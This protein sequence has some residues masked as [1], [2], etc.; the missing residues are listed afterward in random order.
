MKTKIEKYEA[1]DDSI[2]SQPSCTCQ[3]SHWGSVVSECFSCQKRLQLQNERDNISIDVAERRLPDDDTEAGIVVFYQQMPDDI[4]IWC[5]TIWYCQLEIAPVVTKVQIVSTWPDQKS[6]PIFLG[7]TTK[8]V[9]E[10]HFKSVKVTPALSPDS[11]FAPNGRNLTM[12]VNDIGN[13]KIKCVTTESPS[14]AQTCTFSIDE[15]PAYRSLDFVLKEVQKTNNVVIAEQANCSADITLSEFINFGEVRCGGHLQARNIVRAIQSGFLSFKQE[16]VFCLLSQA[17]LQIG[18]FD[19][20]ASSFG[21]KV[22]WLDSTFVAFALKE[23]GDLLEANSRNWMNH[24]VLQTAV[25]LFGYIIRSAAPQRERQAASIALRRCREIGLEWI[26]QIREAAKPSKNLDSKG[27]VD[28]KEVDYLNSIIAQVACSVI[29]SFV[30]STY[31]LASCDDA[32]QFLQASSAL[33]GVLFS[34]PAGSFAKSHVHAAIRASTEVLPTLVAITKEDKGAYLTRFVEQQWALAKAGTVSEWRGPGHMGDHWFTSSFVR[35]TGGRPVQ[36]DISPILGQFLVDGRPIGQLPASVS[37]SDIYK[38]VFGASVLEVY[39]TND[40]TLSAKT[41]NSGLSFLFYPEATPFIVHDAAEG[42]YWLLPPDLFAGT[43]PKSLCKYAAWLFVPRD[44]TPTASGTCEI[45]LRTHSFTDPTFTTA[46][47]RMRV[48]YNVDQP[49]RTASVDWM[50]HEAEQNVLLGINTKAFEKLY[51]VFGRLEDR[52]HIHIFLDKDGNHSARIHLPRHNF[53]FRLYPH[54]EIGSIDY[55]G[56]WVNLKS[57]SCG[58]LVGLR[59]TLLLTSHG[60]PGF[61]PTSLVIVPF[62][63]TFTQPEPVLHRVLH[64]TKPQTNSVPFEASFEELQSPSYFV[65]TVDQT[66]QQLTGKS[67]VSLLYLAFLHSLTAHVLPDLLTCSPGVNVAM[68]IVERCRSNQ[69]FDSACTLILTK[70]LPSTVP[71]REGYPINK[72]TMEQMSY[73]QYSRL[74]RHVPRDSLLLLVKSVYSE[75]RLLE[76]AFL[77]F[78]KSKSSAATAEERQKE[79]AKEQR[80]H[81]I[82]YW[83]S[84]NL[85][86]AEHRLPVQFEDLLLKPT[87]MT[88]TERSSEDVTKDLRTLGQLHRAILSPDQPALGPQIVMPAVISIQKKAVAIKNLEVKPGIVAPKGLAGWLSESKDECHLLVWCKDALACANAL[89]RDEFFWRL[90]IICN[91]SSKLFDIARTLLVLASTQSTSMLPSFDKPF[92]VHKSYSNFGTFRFE[93]D[94]LTSLVSC[95]RSLAFSGKL[96][97]LITQEVETQTKEVV[98]FW[99][100]KHQYWTGG[101][102]QPALS[103]INSKS[104]ADWL[105]AKNKRVEKSTFENFDRAYLLRKRN[106]DLDEFLI[107]L[108]SYVKSI[109][110]PTNLSAATLTPPQVPAQVPQERTGLQP[111][112]LCVNRVPD[113]S[114][115]ILSIWKSNC[116]NSF[117]WAFSKCLVRSDRVDSTSGDMITEPDTFLNDVNDPALQSK[118]LNILK[119]DVRSGWLADQGQAVRMQLRDVIFV[120][121][122]LKACLKKASALS[123]STWKQIANCLEPLE[124]DL[125]GTA[126]KAARLDPSRCRSRILPLLCSVASSLALRK[127]IAAFCVYETYVHRSQQCLLDLEKNNVNFV[128]RGL[129]NTRTARWT[130]ESNPEW[131]LLEV[132]QRITIRE[133]QVKIAQHMMSNSESLP[134]APLLEKDNATEPRSFC[135]QLNMGEGKTSVI[136][137]MLCAALPDGKDRVVRVHVL[138]SLYDSNGDTLFMCLGNLLRRKLFSFPARRDVNLSSKD[139]GI[140]GRQL[141]RA[142][143]SRGVIIT[144]PEHRMSLQLKMQVLHG[145]DARSS[146]EESAL[147][148]LVQIHN[149]YDKHVMNVLDE[150][151]ELL[152]HSFQLIYPVGN[153]HFVDKYRWRVVEEVLS[154]VRALILSDDTWSPLFTVFQRRSPLESAPEWPQTLRLVAQPND[155]LLAN[156]QSVLVDRVLQ[157]KSLTLRNL[158]N[159]LDSKPERRAYVRSL[160]VDGSTRYD[161][162]SHIMPELISEIVLLLRGLFSFDVLDHVLRKRWAV[163]YGT[164]PEGADGPAPARLIAVPY[165]AADTAAERAEFGHTEVAVLST[166]LSYYNEGLSLTRFRQTLECLMQDQSKSEVFISWTPH[167][168]KEQRDVNAINLN[169]ASYIRDL[170]MKFRFNTACIDYWLDTFVFPRD[171]SL[172]PRK[173]IGSAWDLAH[174]SHYPTRGFSGTNDSRMLMP[175]TIRQ[176]DLPELQTTNATVV[177]MLLRRENAKYHPLSESAVNTEKILGEML[178]TNGDAQMLIDAGAIMVGV[179]GRAVM[180]SWFKHLPARSKIHAGVFYENNRLVV[181]DSK[182]HTRVSDFATSPYATNLEHCIVFLDDYHTRGTDLRL[183]VPCHAFVTL[184]DRMAKEKLVQSCMRMRQLGRGHT[185]SFFAMPDVH[186]QLATLSPKPTSA[187][188]LRWAVANAVH[189]TQ[190]ALQQWSQQAFVYNRKLVLDRMPQ[191]ALSSHKYFEFDEVHDLDALYGDSRQEQTLKASI[192]STVVMNQAAFEKILQRFVPNQPT[193]INTTSVHSRLSRQVEAYVGTYAG[194]FKVKT[195]ALD[196][197]QERELEKEQEDEREVHQPPKQT[198]RTPVLPH[199]LRLAVDHADPNLLNNCINGPIPSI[200]AASE[201]AASAQAL[202]TIWDPK[203]LVTKEFVRTI[204]S[205]DPCQNDYLRP[206]NTLLIFWDI[207]RQTLERAVLVSDFEADKLIGFVHNHASTASVSLHRTFL[208]TIPDQP[209]PVSTALTVPSDIIERNEPWRLEQAAPVA[210]QISVLT[211]S[212]TFLPGV[213]TELLTRV[214]QASDTFVRTNAAFRHVGHRVERSLLGTKLSSHSQSHMTK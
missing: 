30:G 121:D 177:G 124:S 58:A 13:K 195:T 133:T 79:S 74:R 178:W 81:T 49:S 213:E 174:S 185:V 19:K 167:L 112:Q 199:D 186:R 156:F 110:V 150:S 155:P 144:V 181:M 69:P 7:S 14:V 75:S 2:R 37:S 113:L 145:K 96:N 43:L 197:E 182:N 157:E 64:G 100:Q 117:E 160:I 104:D 102:L 40:N 48:V 170:H 42:K 41:D 63:S 140:I 6:S 108:D 44:T 171:V 20:V 123:K 146:E 148:A 180:T 70:L 175:S 173:L 196:E 55:E 61:S 1:L 3:K 208:R 147:Q 45:V 26:G 93:R 53:Q 25:G 10:S 190:Y 78:T 50:R 163:D 11:I 83:R 129:G 88:R 8:A 212:L 187:H 47:W 115:E 46:V 84:H 183:P 114:S 116:V 85:L 128:I 66:L 86:S 205:K 94:I 161:G 184:G 134:P 202:A 51:A 33:A 95:S 77:P 54:G 188:I 80:L 9:S 192:K 138:G 172:H 76:S 39:A 127:L 119:E 164:H 122:Q 72:P 135:V 200:Y 91:S 214:S 143:A 92:P 73:P 60:V 137:P 204:E 87:A 154:L 139:L 21:W 31:L 105:L 209:N 109:P 132:Q 89:D 189:R 62:V 99:V 165:R 59:S 34:V 107:H 206:P 158:S 166:L 141:N 126:F 162:A 52:G 22:D 169:D 136:V 193:G 12:A 29:V 82:A 18:P 151:D 101:S 103:T 68:D 118:T 130:P 207:A 191:E 57:Q 32:A 111:R 17:L 28:K 131:L 97:S 152:C 201:L 210:A 56:M 98:D 198:P 120:Q 125:V 211:S 168:P 142:L 90:V 35:S 71:E 194:E 38:S 203:I 67:R 106:C 24:V 27:L 179:D 149:W 23:T 5:N 36:L 16:A 176:Q 159:W 65:Y 153:R 4:R 15:Y